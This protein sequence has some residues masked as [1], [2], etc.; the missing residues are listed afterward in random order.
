MCCLCAARRVRYSRIL[1]TTQFMPIDRKEKT[2]K[3]LTK[4]TAPNNNF[5]GKL[6]AGVCTLALA[7]VLGGSVISLPAY[8][9]D[10]SGNNVAAAKSAAKKAE[11]MKKIDDAARK[12]AQKQTEQKRQTVVSEAVSA[13]RE[14]GNAL[15]YLD[16]G[17]K[18]DALAAIEKAVGKLEVI[19]ARDPELA[20]VPVS[21]SAKSQDIIA[22]PEIVTSMVDEVKKLLYAGKIQEARALLSTLASETVISVAR[23]PL[24]TYPL[25]MKKA[26]A[27]IDEG[28]VNE[29]KVVLQTAL[30]TLDVEVTI[31]PIPVA[32]ARALLERAEKLAE[33]ESRTKE[34]N[35]QLS[36]L[37]SA[38][39]E[40]LRFAQALGYGKRKDFEDFYKEIK[41]IRDKTSGGKSG[42]GFFKKIMG[43]LS[44]V[45]EHSQHAEK[46]AN[47]DNNE[48]H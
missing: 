5:T 8:S 1:F 11:V 16:E 39:E 22:S 3:T 4:N 30:D 44:S 23:L 36:T 20:F 15:K 47:A 6:R 35:E 28:K 21:V 37:L 24:K 9:A 41:V 10:G 14:T 26:A 43:Y 46:A 34:Q 7:V 33:M 25:A 17:K 31:I 2:M 45:T 18:D 29:A 48:K 40:E 38:A 27:L 13:L 12:D 32:N 19:L 42:H